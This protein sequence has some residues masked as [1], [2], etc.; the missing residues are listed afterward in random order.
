M[1]S[2]VYATA[3]VKT[4]KLILQQQQQ[5]QAAG[6]NLF[7]RNVVDVDVEVSC[8]LI[9]AWHGKAWRLSVVWELQQQSDAS[10]Y[11]WRAH[12]NLSRLSL[13]HPRRTVLAG[14][15][16]CNAKSYHLLSLL[17]S[18]LRRS[19]DRSRFMY[20]QR[21]WRNERKKQNKKAFLIW[22]KQTNKTNVAPLFFQTFSRHG[23]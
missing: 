20:Y 22:K 11:R 7:R 3:A 17:R 5:Q 16:Y 6:E 21:W 9:M 12:Q 1:R 13:S 18:A 15:I 4:N 2:L 23:D 14:W 8:C 10:S 19:L